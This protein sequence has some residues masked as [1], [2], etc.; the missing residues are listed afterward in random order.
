M[1][2]HAVGDKQE[3]K[4]KAS[5][6][7][8]LF[9]LTNSDPHPLPPHH[10]HSHRH[11][12]DMS[13]PLLLPR[14]LGG[15]AGRETC[16]AYVHASLAL[17]RHRQQTR[18]KTTAAAASTLAARTARGAGEARGGGKG[19]SNLVHLAPALS[20]QQHQQRAFSGG[21][22]TNPIKA[23]ITGSLLDARVRVVGN[24]KMGIIRSLPVCLAP[25]QS[26]YSPSLPPPS[27]PTEPRSPHRGRHGRGASPHLRPRGRADVR[28]AVGG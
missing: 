6:F 17:G 4:K 21:G 1:R 3:A 28:G 7:P 26:L 13:L 15:S 14:R 22:K 11:A 5:K 16:F 23:K 25:T 9:A 12:Q 2:E 10:H 20:Q 24:D 27:L 19:G 8:C 18:P